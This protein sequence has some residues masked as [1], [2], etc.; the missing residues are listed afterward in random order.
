MQGLELKSTDSLHSPCWFGQFAI[1][2]NALYSTFLVI[3][4]TSSL[5]SLDTLAKL[6]WLISFF[7]LDLSSPSPVRTEPYF[8]VS[9]L[10]NIF[11]F[12]MLF[13]YLFIMEDIE[14]G[15]GFLLL[16]TSPKLTAAGTGRFY[17][18]NERQSFSI[19]WFTPYMS[20]MG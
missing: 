11:F 2:T 9:E 12:P 20:T 8:L 7:C 16:I 3:H 18:E 5:G 4:M 10:L 17:R 6:S 14:A 19:Y 15:S 1:A 13:V